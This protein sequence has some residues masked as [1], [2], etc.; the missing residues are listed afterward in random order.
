MTI[1]QEQITVSDPVNKPEHYG[2]GSIESIEYIEDFLT[3]EE[4]KGFLRGNISKYLHRYR[5]KGKPVEDLKKAQ[6]YLA[7]LIEKEE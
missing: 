1:P 6:W 7:R 3:D 4:Y 5:Y 2:Q